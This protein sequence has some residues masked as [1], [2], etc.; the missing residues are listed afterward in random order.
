MPR[1]PQKTLAELFKAAV[2]KHGSLS[3]VARH[4]DMEQSQVSRI[5][6]GIQRSVKFKSVDKA[7][8][9]LG[10]SISALA[11][12][13]AIPPRRRAVKRPSGQTDMPGASPCGPKAGD[14]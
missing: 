3:A 8:K 14:K 2:K 9:C 4:C 10:I 7:A 11:L 1:R 13:C 5:V 6:A 12:A